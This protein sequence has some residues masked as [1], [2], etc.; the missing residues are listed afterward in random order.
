MVMGK[1]RVGRDED[2]RKSNVIWEW[3]Y[4][5]KWS[6]VLHERGRLWDIPGSPVAKRLQAPSVGGPGWI[7]GQGTRSHMPHLS[8]HLPQQRLK[9]PRVHS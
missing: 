2:E 3:E 4:S 8:V 7:P 5:H 6:W 9:I 1:S